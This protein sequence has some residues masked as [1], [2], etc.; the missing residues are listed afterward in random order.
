MSSTKVESA[1]ISANS[2]IIETLSPL[3]QEYESAFESVSTS[4][5]KLSDRLETLLNDLRRVA[6][7]SANEP[8]PGSPGTIGGYV[9]K[10][11]SLRKRLDVVNYS[12][13]RVSVRLESL[14]TAVSNT[15]RATR[16]KAAAAAATAA[17][18]GISVAQ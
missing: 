6:S 11:E 1:R 3:V 2:A 5:K 16:M 13:S 4:Q 15:E 12:M 9:R 8:E 17:I 7:T 14:Q 18:E 10:I